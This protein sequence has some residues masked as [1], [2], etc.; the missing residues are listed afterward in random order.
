M[1]IKI[2]TTLKE[3]FKDVLAHKTEW[4][5]VA[6]SPAGLWFLGL[7]FMISLHLWVG[8]PIL[9][10]NSIGNQAL[11]IEQTREIPTLIIFSNI[12]YYIIYIIA[13]FNLY[14][15]GFRYAIFQE[16]GDRWFNL[17]LNRRFFTMIVYSLLIS[18]IAGLYALIVTGITIG[19]HYS[20]ESLIL[21]ATVAT[22]LAAFG[23]YLI[24][25]IS[26]AFLF[27][28][29]DQ[30]KP[31]NKSWKL[32]KGNVSRLLGLILL[33]WISIFL[34]SAI[35]IVILGIFGWIFYL[36]HPPLAGIALLFIILFALS[37]W[38][39]SWAIVS[40][41]L[42]LVYKDLRESTL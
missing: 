40:K 39:L 35:G 28:S 19:I 4:V 10:E 7:V 21:T 25:R 30:K 42:S 32:L 5:R 18:I 2:T 9:P 1:K 20:V 31:I 13:I 16:A 6:F 14:I 33:I 23:F 26:L 8:H 22:L 15:N 3:S 27:I 11:N 17:H 12:V 37:M 24:L 38:L 34:V 36:I 41:S 29:I